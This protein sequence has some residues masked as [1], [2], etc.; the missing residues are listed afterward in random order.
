MAHHMRLSFFLLNFL[1]LFSEQIQLGKEI[2][3]VEVVDTCETR[4]RGLMGRESLEEGQGMLFVY[5]TPEKLTFWM[6]N[7]KIPLSIAFF[8]EDKIL[9]NSLDMDVPK[10]NSLLLYRSEGPAKY[11]LEVPQGWFKKHGIAKGTK[12]SFLD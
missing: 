3:R 6:K 12:F 4:A 9:V 8:N 2:I 5:E 1:L 7:T 10:G 11:A